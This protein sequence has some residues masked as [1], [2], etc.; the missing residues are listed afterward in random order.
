MKTT[1][2][3]PMRI[4]RQAGLTLIE[5]MVALT[6]GLF[7]SFGLV[8]MMSDSSRTFRIQDDYAR[9]Q[10]NAV[11]ALRYI[12]DSLRHAGFYGVMSQTG[13]LVQY[14][15]I[16]TI[17]ND[18]GNTFT[19]DV[20][21]FGYADL[22][23]A[24]VNSTLPCIKAV[25]FQAG[26]VLVTR[27]TTGMPVADPNGDGNFADGVAAQPGYSTTLYVQSNVQDGVIVRGDGY[28]AYVASG[29]V[30]KYASGAQFPV[31]PYQVH[32][33]YIRPCSR[34]TGGASSDECQSTDDSGHPVPTLVRQELQGTTMVEQPLAEGVERINLMYGLDTQPA[35]GDGVADRFVADP[36]SV[37]ADGWAR[38][39][40]VRIT[41]LV[42]SPTLIAGYDD[43]TKSYDLDGNG[44]YDASIDFRCANSTECAYKRAI[45]S[46]VIQVRNL[47]FR[48]GA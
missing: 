38:V 11:S 10:E 3:I 23:T 41:L 13:T 9:M 30:K 19:T 8:L 28:A 33:Y 35:E 34:P 5:L 16:G 42:R 48:R 36:L 18:C 4:A 39:V 31:F 6:I 7:L 1:A 17:T 37:V 15:T 44:S 26:P 43:S 14:G 25:N 27:L 32:V 21:V 12:G 20:P 22:T 24:N 40:A 29:P 45:F 47:A 2:I 46:Q